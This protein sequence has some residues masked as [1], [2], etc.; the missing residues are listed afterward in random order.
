MKKEYE[1]HSGIRMEY[2]VE[3]FVWLL[4]LSNKSSIF[5]SNEKVIQIQSSKYDNWLTI[6]A[7]QEPENSGR[8]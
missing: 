5:I 1:I 7:N 8:D 2:R 3:P 4:S 6:S